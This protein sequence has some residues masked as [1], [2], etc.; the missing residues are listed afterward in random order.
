MLPH[1]GVDIGKR[2]YLNRVGYAI[3]QRSDM[4]TSLIE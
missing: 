2:D 3:R 1:N 4:E